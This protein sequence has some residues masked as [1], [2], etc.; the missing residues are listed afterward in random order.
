M[1]L[2][3]KEQQGFELRFV[4]VEGKTG[5]ASVELALPMTAASETNLLGK[6]SAEV[7]IS[8]GKLNFSLQP[9]RLRT[10]EIGV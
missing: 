9:W 3:A 7:S 1:V 10:F 6:K 4:E 2:R 5:D 8:A